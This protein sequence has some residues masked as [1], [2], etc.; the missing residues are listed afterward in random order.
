MSKARNVPM[1]TVSKGRSVTAINASRNKRDNY[2]YSMKSTPIAVEKNSAPTVSKPAPKVTKP[3][4]K[5][6]NTILRAMKN[7]KK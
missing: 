1:T 2:D 4:N 7:Q 6:R 3:N 5:T